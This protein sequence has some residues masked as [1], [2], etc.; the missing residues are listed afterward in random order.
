VEHEEPKE[1]T[2]EPG[3]LDNPEEVA[4]T[5]RD[6]PTEPESNIKI[7]YEEKP[8]EVKPYVAKHDKNCPK[9]GGTGVV[10]NPEEIAKIHDSNEYKEGIRKIK[11]NTNNR[12]LKDLREVKN[13]FLLQQYKC[14]GQ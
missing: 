12:N 14:K 13:A 1:I 11:A 7:E 9:C 3:K 2:Q 5:M 8:E 10:N 6:L 4:H